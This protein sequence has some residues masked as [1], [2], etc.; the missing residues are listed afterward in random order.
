MI[1]QATR[2]SSKVKITGVAAS[3]PNATLRVQLFGSPTARADGE[4]DGMAKVPSRCSTCCAG[5]CYTALG[6]T[7]CAP[8]YAPVYTGRAGGIEAY[9]GA[10]LVG[11]TLCVDDSAT[12]LATYA[13]GY[14]TRMM[15]YR[16][17]AGGSENGMD[18]VSN[19]CAVCCLQ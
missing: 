13:S 4:G 17:T 6:T 2:T 18:A 11:K 14:A 12:A 15:R 1:Q 7:S 8:G 10:S 9:S 16:E 19:A 5:G 3:R